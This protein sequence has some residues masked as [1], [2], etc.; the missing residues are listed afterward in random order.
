[1][2]DSV[3]TQLA[4]ISPA[5]YKWASLGVTALVLLVV[6]FVVHLDGKPHAA[7][8]QFLGRFH[9]LAVHLPIGLVVL[10]PVLEVAGRRKAALREA[11]GFVLALG[12]ALC[13]GTFALGYLLAYGSGEAG[14]TMDRHMWGAIV[15]VILLLLC[16]MI[17][18]LWYEGVDS[19]LY[20]ILLACAVLTM[21]WTA[22]QGGSLTRGSNYL[23]EYMPNPLKRVVAFAS[24]SADSGNPD[25]FYA[26][27]VHPI[28]DTHCVSC[29]GSGKS[30]ADLRLDTYDG[31][32]HG[33]KSGRAVAPG[34]PAR[35]LLLARVTLPPNDK[36]FMPA[37]GRPP[38]SPGDVALVRAWIQQGASSTSRSIAGFAATTESVQLRPVGDYSSLMSEI[39]R[40]RKSQG[41]KLL[42][43]SSKASDGLILSTFDVTAGFGDAQL[44]QLEKFA[45]YIV[46]A[47]LAR[48]GIT[49]ASLETLSHFVHLRALHLEGTAISGNGLAK[50]KSLPELTYL[51][52]SETEVTRA[53]IAP[54]QSMPNLR[55][56]YLFGTP[57]QPDTAKDAAQS[58]S[59]T[60]R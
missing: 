23:T 27:R 20:P 9:P 19:R 54:L 17:R 46:E 18:P 24:G 34:D 36:H 2:L 32:L 30:N 29:H 13:L 55:H 58:N 4:K 59:E 37:E 26:L 53:A 52:L 31:L 16:V 47:D 12:S 42:A 6:P 3:G 11:A 15:F 50:L 1:M 10:I 14:T 43:V 21:I 7:W 41:A 57:A 45:P 28:L 38:L 48:T 60:S 8:E 33:G 40:M 22:H 5:R 25:S 56:L 35:S 49:D 51:N 39:S 44:Q